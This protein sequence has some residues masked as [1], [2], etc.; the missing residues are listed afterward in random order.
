MAQIKSRKHKK[1]VSMVALAAALPLAAQATTAE[2][3]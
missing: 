3:N 2:S 1:T